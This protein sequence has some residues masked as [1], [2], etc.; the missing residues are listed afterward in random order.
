MTS[1]QPRPYR[2]GEILGMPDGVCVV[3]IC[4][5]DAGEDLECAGR[6]LL[7]QP[8]PRCSAGAPRSLGDVRPGAV[9]WDPATGVEIRCIRGGCGPIMHGGRAM[10]P[11]SREPLARL[12]HLV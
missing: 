5:T 10:V 7:P 1:T 4:G 3:V 12:R 8:P 2:A 9:L 6:K 11:R